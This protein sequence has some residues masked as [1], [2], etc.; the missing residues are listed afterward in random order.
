MLDSGAQVT[1]RNC[2]ELLKF[3]SLE[4]V[5]NPAKKVGVRTADGNRHEVYVF[6]YVPFTFNDT[7]KVLQTYI[8]PSLSKTLFCGMDFWA[9]FDIG[10]S[11]GPESI[12]TIESEEAEAANSPNYSKLHNLTE[13]QKQ[14]LGECVKLL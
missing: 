12:C 1:G 2:L 14:Q 8:V 11:I 7:T 9:A 4:I 3:V 13:Q 5:R 10:I 6:A